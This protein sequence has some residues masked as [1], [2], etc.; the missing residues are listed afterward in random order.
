MLEGSNSWSSTNFP[1]TIWLTNFAGT[2]ENLGPTTNSWCETGNKAKDASPMVL[3]GR[4]TLRVLE[5]A[6]WASK[7]RNK[8]NK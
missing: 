7:W 6:E 8:Y 1:A 4:A 2:G 3:E 5:E